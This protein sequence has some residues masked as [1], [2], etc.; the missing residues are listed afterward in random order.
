MI[1]FS[2]IIL[3]LAIS[4]SCLYSEGAIGKIESVKGE[5]FIAHLLKKKQPVEVGAEV[6]EKDKIQ[7]GGDGEVVVALAESKLTIGPNAYTKISN[8]KEEASSTQL[9]L[10]GGKVGFKVN[11]LSSE[12]SFTVR[13][14]SAVAGVRGTE[15]EVNFDGEGVTGTSS[16]PHQDPN[17]SPSI[18]YTATPENEKYMKDSIRESRENEANGRSDQH[19]EGND[20]VNVLPE[21]HVSVHFPD[22]ES[23]KL[24][25]TEGLELGELSNQVK[26]NRDRA[27]A[28]S[29]F[30]NKAAM[31]A[32]QWAEIFEDRLESIE[33]ARGNEELPGPPSTPLTEG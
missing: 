10:Y 28:E 17:A 27:R 12:Q 19:P 25:N 13:T 29:A 33:K 8:E 26:N 31:D 5:A 20:R 18:V 6:F 1:K 16:L 22:G 9:A 24:E 30:S 32:A 15:G 14:P 2:R 11:K 21:H 23:I 7:T 3:P 4:F